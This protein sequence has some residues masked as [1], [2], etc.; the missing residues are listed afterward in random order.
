MKIIIS[1]LY[2]CIA[3]YSFIS[4]KTLYIEKSFGVCETKLVQSV[5]PWSSACFYGSLNNKGASNEQ[6]ELEHKMLTRFTSNKGVAPEILL[7]RLK[8]YQKHQNKYR[9]SYRDIHFM[10]LDYTQ[11][12]HSVLRQQLEYLRFLKNRQLDQLAQ[13]TLDGYCERFIPSKRDDIVS[14][15]EASLIANDINLNINS[16]RAKTES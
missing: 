5:V 15:L 2:A 10:Y 1:V 8:F 16:C 9:K 6:V 7:Y 3:G 11:H 13:E 4:A 14:K 12:Q